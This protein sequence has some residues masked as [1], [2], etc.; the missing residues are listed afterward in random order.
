MVERSIASFLETEDYHRSGTVGRSYL[1]FEL[2]L[3]EKPGRRSSAIFEEDLT[4]VVSTS[5]IR[6]SVGD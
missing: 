3:S 6:Y 1:C 5:G 2:S 4:P